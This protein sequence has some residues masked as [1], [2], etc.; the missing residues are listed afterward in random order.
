MLNFF[1]EYEIDWTA[2]SA[3]ATFLA[4]LVALYPIWEERHR[5]RLIAINL[6]GRAYIK[7]QLLKPG[8]KMMFD[9]AMPVLKNAFTDEELNAIQMLESI[10]ANPSG[11]DP[12]ELDL[13]MATVANLGI[14][15]AFAQSSYSVDKVPEQAEFTYDLVEKSIQLLQSKQY[16]PIE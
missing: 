16:R 10:I 7:L 5:R 14:L 15:S 1:K 6:R 9:S 12:Q 2:L 13:L 8:I 3:I 4:V 11:L